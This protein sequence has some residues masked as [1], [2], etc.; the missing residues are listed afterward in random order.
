L[1]VYH[2][3]VTTAKLD[4]ADLR[5]YA[6]HLTLPEVGRE[7][8][9]RLRAA[10]VLVVGVG[11]LG[12]PAALYLAAAGVGTL[13]LV[14]FDA[15]EESNLQ[16]QI[17]FGQSDVGKP[18][19]AVAAD[20]L[21]AAH[22][23]LAVELHDVRL[24][25]SNALDIVGRYDIVLDGSDNLP[26][27]YLVNDA[28]VLTG[29]PDVYGSIFRFE[30]QVSLFWG[31]R[32][33]CYRCLFPEPPPP[34]LVPSCAEGGVLGVLPGVIGTL[35]ASETIKWIVGAG[36][37]ALGRLV[38]F[39]ALGLRFRELRVRKD[40]DCPVCG[41]RPTLRELIDYEGFCGMHEEPKAAS[42]GVTGLEIAPR[43]LAE[44]RAARRPLVLLDVRTPEE[45]SFGVIDGAVMLPL[46][47]LP[48]RLDELDRQADIVAYC[49][50]G[51]RSL[52]A[53]QW[54]RDAGFERV[55]SLRGGTEAW[56]VEV[57][58]AVARY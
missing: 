25:R 32:G 19:L 24:D 30:G 36:E 54:L 9:E 42:S 13:G 7:G 35:Q 12:S 5:R 27:R 3:G 56:S 10:R 53:A 58:P 45:W 37:L 47:E 1:N 38:I 14:D 51:V 18:K 49:H 23:R 28:C 50:L 15:V 6:R 57:D 29:R 8:Q 39:D 31:E 20:R 17:L 40:P 33:P 26:T 48:Q 46:H 43:E 52:Y 41:E 2:S 55:W 21:R 22:P 16:R 34:A 44:W 11:G 4:T